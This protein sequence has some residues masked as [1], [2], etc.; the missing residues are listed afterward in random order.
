MLGVRPDILQ[1]AERLQQKI[2][3][4]PQDNFDD[5]N[6]E[7]ARAFMQV[8]ED[9]E[10]LRELFSEFYDKNKE[11]VQKFR[12]SRKGGFMLPTEAPF[13]RR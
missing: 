8:T 5:Q 1:E 2:F 13:D 10:G 7:A 6:Y 3:Q 4:I 12:K 11:A 9:A